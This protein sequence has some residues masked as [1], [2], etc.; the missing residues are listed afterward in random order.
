MIQTQENKELPRLNRVIQV[1]ILE[2]L[3][4][5]KQQKVAQLNRELNGN[6]L[7]DD[8]STWNWRDDYHSINLDFELMLLIHHKIIGRSHLVGFMTFDDIMRVALRAGVDSFTYVF[9]AR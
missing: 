9:H 4:F 7:I 6:M 3:T 8:V 2:K 5:M 1:Q